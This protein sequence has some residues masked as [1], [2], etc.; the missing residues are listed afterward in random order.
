MKLLKVMKYI[1][2]F[3]SLDSMSLNVKYININGDG[4]PK[5]LEADDFTEKEISMIDSLVSKDII[6]SYRLNTYSMITMNMDYLSNTPLRKFQDEYY[7]VYLKNLM[8]KSPNS[9][10]LLIDGKDSFRKLEQIIKWIY[11]DKFNIKI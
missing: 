9:S 4:W 7:I 11:L 10:I 6:N 8:F 1:K 5:V 3:E 2:L